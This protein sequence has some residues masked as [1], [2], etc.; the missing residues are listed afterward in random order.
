[1]SSTRDHPI[2][3]TCSSPHAAAEIDEGAEVAHRRDAAGHHGARH[4]RFPDRVRNRPL[5]RL[6]QHAPGHDEVPALP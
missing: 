1:M 2:S 5:L 3:D 4:D 6:E